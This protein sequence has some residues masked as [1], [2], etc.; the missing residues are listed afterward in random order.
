MLKNIERLR[1]DVET[2]EARL[3]DWMPG[4]WFGVSHYISI[5]SIA[6]LVFFIAFAFYF[7]GFYCFP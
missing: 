5:A 7:D 1:K 4:L 3:S 2:I 6:S